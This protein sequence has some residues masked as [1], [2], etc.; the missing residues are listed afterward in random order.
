MVNAKIDPKF[1][2]R[3]VRGVDVVFFYSNALYLD[4]DRAVDPYSFF[5]DLDTAAF[6][7]ADPDPSAF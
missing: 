5:A 2:A 6:L 4:P 3:E 7:N 1:F